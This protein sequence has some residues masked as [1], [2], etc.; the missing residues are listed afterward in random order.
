[1]INKLIEVLVFNM[2]K[3]LDQSTLIKKFIQTYKKNEYNIH[4]DR[5]VYTIYMFFIKI[6]YP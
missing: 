3:H 1:M 2:L 6:L 4:K 5:K